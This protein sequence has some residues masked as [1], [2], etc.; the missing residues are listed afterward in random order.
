MWVV[1]IGCQIIINSG[2]NSGRIALSTIQEL[3]NVI[4]YL[5]IPLQIPTIYQLSSQ[6][7]TE[8]ADL[9]VNGLGQ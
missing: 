5:C 7:A 1:T 8:V 2:F 4:V 3:E 9:G 6:S